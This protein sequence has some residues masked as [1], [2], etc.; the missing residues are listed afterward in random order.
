MTHILASFIF[1]IMESSKITKS[2]FKLI[3][4]LYAQRT[5]FGKVHQSSGA[6]VFTGKELINYMMSN[7]NETNMNRNEMILHIRNDLANSNSTTRFVFPV[8][9]NNKFKCGG[10]KFM[11]MPDYLRFLASDPKVLNLDSE[12]IIRKNDLLFTEMKEEE[13]SSGDKKKTKPTYFF[14]EQFSTFEALNDMEILVKEIQYTMLRIK[15]QT[16]DPVTFHVDYGKVE[17]I[18]DFKE[19][20]QY[21]VQLL[22]FVDLKSITTSKRV[23]LAFFI[24][25]YNILTIHSLVSWNQLKGR[26]TMTD[27]ERTD[28]FNLFKYCIGGYLFSLN[29]IEHG[30]LRSEDNFG[31]SKMRVIFAGLF[32]DSFS[33][34]SRDRFDKH[35]GRKQLVLTKELIGKLIFH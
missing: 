1:F 17:S 34:K 14:E 10:K 21:L 3:K 19:D 32:T 20:F 18:K 8:E 5:K 26:F 7:H 27:W 31:N 11:F 33:D 13:N 35:D 16:I 15:G 22:P 28:Y 30:L 25:L 4:S 23:N 6:I 12:K 29:D 2:A 24:N 9:H